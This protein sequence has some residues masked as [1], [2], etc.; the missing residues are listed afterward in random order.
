[1]QR[2]I[3][4]LLPLTELGRVAPVCTFWY[5]AFAREADRL[6]HAYACF[7]V[8]KDIGT[9]D[10][11]G[12]IEPFLPAPLSEGLGRAWDTACAY[13]SKPYHHSFSCWVDE[14]GKIVGGVLPRE[15]A[16]VNIYACATDRSG[17]FCRGKAWTIWDISILCNIPEPT[18]PCLLN[19]SFSCMCGRK[20]RVMGPPTMQILAGG[21]ETCVLLYSCIVQMIGERLG[22]T[23]EMLAQRLAPR[24]VA[25]L[26]TQKRGE[27]FIQADAYIFGLE[28]L[29]LYRTFR[30]NNHVI[31]LVS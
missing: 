13:L 28:K 30:K 11:Y 24:G 14:D 7:D 2:H 12:M 15:K 3:L 29:L 20:G 25:M 6:R 23:L 17:W 27:A 9:V 26:P 16:F 31:R 10:V 4:G 21:F 18:A 8:R 1:V 22:G 5:S 19:L